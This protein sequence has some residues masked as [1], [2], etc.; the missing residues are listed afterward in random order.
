MA[1]ARC[2]DRIATTRQLD[3]R[4]AKAQGC[5]SLSFHTTELKGN[6]LCE[7]QDSHSIF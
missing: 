1:P 3:E 2:P 6:Q 5:N 7:D 4:C